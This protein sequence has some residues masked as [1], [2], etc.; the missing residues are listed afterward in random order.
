MPL[1]HLGIDDTDS[2]KR[3]CTTYI[4]A[5]LVERLAGRCNFVDYPNLIRLNPNV[6]WKS[7]GNA[8]ICLRFRSDMGPTQLMEIAVDLVERNRDNADEKNQPGIALL[9]G[10]V[11]YALKDYGRRALFDVLT[12]DEARGMADRTGMRSHAIRGGRGLIGAV[13]S[14]GNT[15][16]G[17]HTFELAV[18]RREE[19]W[20]RR[21]EVDYRSVVEFDQEEG[22]RTFNN[23]DYEKERLLVTPRGPDPILFG[24]RGEAPSV[25]IRALKVIRFSGAERWVIWRSNQG[26]GAHLTRAKAIAELRPYE[27]AVINGTVSQGPRTIRGGHVI[28]T[29]RDFSGEIDIAGYEPSGSFR[30]IVGGLMPGDKVRAFG[31]VRPLEE[32]KLT[33]NLERLEVLEQVTEVRMNPRCPD[34]GKSM[35]SEGK[36]KGYQCRR[37]GARSPHAALVGISRATPTGVFLPP[38][39]AMRHLTKPPIREGRQKSSRDAGIGPFYGVF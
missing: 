25:V 34:C 10:E 37:C 19:F 4:G 3:G 8:A 30:A 20:G 38:P 29:I 6:P 15:L 16:E 11:P 36:G 13:A 5:L 28:S 27:A 26:T 7:R 21:R 18:Y 12:L 1:F 39:R 2:L 24:V 35:K 32:G 31:G 9:E 23:I 14:I 17:D 22:P 33:F